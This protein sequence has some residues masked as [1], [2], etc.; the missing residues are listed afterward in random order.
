[1]PLTMVGTGAIMMTMTAKMSPE[2]RV[3]R[4]GTELRR[5]VQSSA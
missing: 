2:K 5:M 3:N 1:M 4:F